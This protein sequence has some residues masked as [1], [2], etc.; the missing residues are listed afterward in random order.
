MRAAGAV[1]GA[2]FAVA[3][4]SLGSAGFIALDA[5]VFDARQRDEA[6][7]WPGGAP[8]E[9][10][11]LPGLAGSRSRRLAAAG[12]S[13]ARLESEGLGLS[14]P[15]VEGIE[16]RALRRAVGHVPGSAFPGETGNVVLAAHRDMH[17]RPLHGAQA[18]DL[19]RLVTPDGTFL[20]GVDSTEVVGPFEVA[21][22]KPTASPQLTLITCYP[23]SFV[24]P[25]PQ[26]FVVKATLRGRM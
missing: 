5:R 1:Q 13:W 21:V 18:G 24:G 16:P 20:Y 6:R 23:F 11:S 15:V 2:L 26:R 22:M 12:E 4:A 10:G 7:A 17:F 9:P 19:L 25:A 14:A 8:G 3:V